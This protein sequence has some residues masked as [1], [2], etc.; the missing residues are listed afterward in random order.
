MKYHV[1]ICKSFHGIYR[2][3]Y[4]IKV[5]KEYP[6]SNSAENR[7]PV[8][9]QFKRKI[10]YFSSNHSLTKFTYKKQQDL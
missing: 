8:V 1:C 4:F 10:H 7:A 9:Q 3:F 5:T 2:H 6:K